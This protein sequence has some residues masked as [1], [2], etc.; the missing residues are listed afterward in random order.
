MRMVG[1]VALDAGRAPGA[2]AGAHAV[3]LACDL[4][5]AEEQGRGAAAGRCAC[6]RAQGSAPYAEPNPWS[7]RW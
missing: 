2:S 3:A 4:C 7:P 1:T 5:V 6:A